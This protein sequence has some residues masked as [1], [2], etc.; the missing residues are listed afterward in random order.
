MFIE[1]LRSAFGRPI[2]LSKRLLQVAPSGSPEMQGGT[3][4]FTAWLTLVLSTHDLSLGFCF[5]Q[6]T[7]PCEQFSLYIHPY[8]FLSGFSALY[9]GVR[10]TQIA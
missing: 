7:I 5:A 8:S 10:K 2:R 1:D 6:P 3:S 9:G 4:P